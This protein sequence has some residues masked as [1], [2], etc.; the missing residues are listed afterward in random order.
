MVGGWLHLLVEFNII[1]QVFFFEALIQ[2]FKVEDLK[3]LTQKL[4]PKEDW[5]SDVKVVTKC[6]SEQNKHENLESED[7]YSAQISSCR[8][9]WLVRIILLGVDIHQVILIDPVFEEK[10]NEANEWNNRRDCTEE[11]SDSP[12]YSNE[13]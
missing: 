4:N 9:E 8:T 10:V 6:K 11:D 12:D 1:Y 2:F 13:R 5:G 3:E 7:G